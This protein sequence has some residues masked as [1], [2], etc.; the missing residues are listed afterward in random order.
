M[1]WAGTLRARKRMQK[2]VYLLQAAGCPL[3]ADYRLHRFGPYSQEVAQL[4]DELAGLGVLQEERIENTAGQQ[5]NYTLTE[6]GAKALADAERTPSAKEMR[7]AMAGF[8]EQARQL[9][10][11][12]LRELEVASTMAYF[13]RQGCDWP[14]AR[15]KTC[16]FKSLRPEDPAVQNAE[17]LARRIVP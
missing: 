2:V 13:R 7:A 17:G 9:F 14:A 8:E 15:E 10:S 12:D 1:Q 6:E 4:S 5:Y 3:G 11:A 16:R